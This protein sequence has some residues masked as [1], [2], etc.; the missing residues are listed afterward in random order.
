MKKMFVILALAVFLAA[1]CSRSPAARQVVA[2]P[3]APYTQ[4]LTVGSAKI[5][6]DVAD[7][8]SRWAQGLSGRDPLRDDQ[9]M[10]FD[11]HSAQ[12]V[13]PTFWMKD[14]KFPLDLV[15]INNGKIIGITKSVPQPQPGTPDADLPQYHPP[16]PVTE[17]LEVRGGWSDEHGVGVGDAVTS[18][19]SP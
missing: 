13:T 14:M 5:F 7:T 18:K 1:A 6:V 10:L 12:P 19:G 9:G 15:W 3:Q 16:A 2:P 11:F 17:V 4:P 8:P